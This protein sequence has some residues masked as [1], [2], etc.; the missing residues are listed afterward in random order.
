MSRTSSASASCRLHSNCHDEWAGDNP[1]VCSELDADVVAV[2][3]VVV[4]V[5]VIAVVAF[6]VHLRILRIILCLRVVFTSCRR[7]TE[8]GS[9]NEMQLANCTT[10]EVFARQCQFHA[11][12]RSDWSGWLYRKG[13][14][15]QLVIYKSAM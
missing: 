4:V 7:K 5:A 10:V 14:I 9:V 11:L 6:V 13:F 2:V 15:S 3:V 1:D 8:N 12:L